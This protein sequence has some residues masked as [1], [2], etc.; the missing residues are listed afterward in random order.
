MAPLGTRFCLSHIPLIQPKLSNGT[1]PKPSDIVIVPSFDL[2]IELVS[3][4]TRK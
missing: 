2:F 4:A 1:M 3:V